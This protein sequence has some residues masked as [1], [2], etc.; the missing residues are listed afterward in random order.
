MTVAVHVSCAPIQ[1]EGRIPGH[2]MVQIGLVGREGFQR[3]AAEQNYA[4][5]RGSQQA[6]EDWAE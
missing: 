3:Q 2:L 6:E 4:E 1:P 5:G